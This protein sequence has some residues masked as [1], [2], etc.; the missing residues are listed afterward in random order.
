MSVQHCSNCKSR[1][2]QRYR[3]NKIKYLISHLDADFI[4]KYKEQIHTRQNKVK[5]LFS[6]WFNFVTV[7]EKRWANVI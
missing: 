2:E 3:W 1:H 4:G 5:R 7:A 6:M